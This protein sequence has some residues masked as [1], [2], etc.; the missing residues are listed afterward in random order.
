MTDVREYAAK[1]YIDR[2]PH[3]NSILN[4]LENPDLTP[5]RIR[6]HDLAIP[7]LV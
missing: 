4:A 1:G 3:Y 7:P 2:A 6:L 5:R